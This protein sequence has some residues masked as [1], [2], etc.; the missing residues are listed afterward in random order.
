MKFFCTFI[1]GVAER[2]RI[3]PGD[4]IMFLPDQHALR[5]RHGNDRI[6]PSSRGHQETMEGVKICDA[7]TFQVI[8]KLVATAHRLGIEFES[9]QSFSGTF[10]AWPEADQ[11]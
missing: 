5:I 4:E 9:E 6:M 3:Q 11:Q 7:H 8:A 1:K 2:T 10:L